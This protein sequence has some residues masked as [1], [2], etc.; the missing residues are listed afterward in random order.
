MNKVQK[1]KSE[2]INAQRN[3]TNNNIHELWCYPNNITSDNWFKQIVISEHWEKLEGWYQIDSLCISWWNNG[4]S[5]KRHSNSIN[6]LT[7]K[8]KMFIL[9][10]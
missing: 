3:A 2:K 7:G 10:F 9:G 1:Q 5:K 8:E 4:K 6:D